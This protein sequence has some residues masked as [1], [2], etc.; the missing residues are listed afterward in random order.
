MMKKAWKTTIFS[1]L[2]FFPLL[3]GGLIIALEWNIFCGMILVMIAISF[4]CYALLKVQ[5]Q[6][7]EVHRKPPKGT[8]RIFKKEKV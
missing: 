3:F 8:L 7:G 1:I 5:K 6:E 2:T 4:A